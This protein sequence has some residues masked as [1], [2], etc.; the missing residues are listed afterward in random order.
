MARGAKSPIRTTP[1]TRT[2]D[3][4]LKAEWASYSGSLAPQH[5]RHLAQRLTVVRDTA[6]ANPESPEKRR[7]EKRMRADAYRDRRR[8]DGAARTRAPRTH[9]LSRGARRRSRTQIPRGLATDQELM[10]SMR[11]ER[12]LA[13]PS[14]HP[15]ARTQH[16]ATRVGLRELRPSGGLT[17]PVPRSGHPSEQSR[18]GY[19]AAPTPGHAAAPGPRPSTCR[20]RERS[21]KKLRY[22]ARHPRHA[23]IGKPRRPTLQPI[24]ARIAFGFH[25]S[26]GT[27]ACHRGDD[28]SPRIH[29]AR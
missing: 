6:R 22:R 12:N 15:I 1:M 9:P 26:R 29:G 10:K 8:D 14:K 23:G 5:R 13:W 3:H 17:T 16:G 11:A 19:C 25:P 27:G 7:F 2:A 21:R 24:V 4:G 18:A 28:R 20:S